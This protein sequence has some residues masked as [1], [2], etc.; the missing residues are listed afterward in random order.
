MI[1]RRQSSAQEL[2][3][4]LNSAPASTE[5]RDLAQAQWIFVCA[6]DDALPVLAEAM[7]VLPMPW[8]DLN[9]AHTSGTLGAEVFDT[10]ATMGAT[11]CS[12]HPAV[13]LSGA[14]DDWQKISTATFGI[15]G[16]GE[17]L[18]RAR[19]LLQELGATAVTI[20]VG[21][22]IGYHLACVLVSN[23]LVT[24]HA[25]ALQVL[26]GA[27]EDDALRRLLMELS[28]DTL[29]NL[30]SQPPAI[31]LTGPI[32]RGDVGTVAAHLEFLKNKF[33]TLLELYVALGNETLKYARPS[34]LQE[35]E[36]L[37]AKQISD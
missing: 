36:K 23:Y 18:V 22:K 8:K 2:V 13:S 14:A 30:S 25:M 11:A 35:F 10:L 3:R 21:G 16:G 26:D 31:A 6:P 34:K 17:A 37:F 27:P 32:V 15:E 5:V 20:P 4:L 33:P 24:L 7:T 1:S 29:K 19:N 28:R 9:V 12:M